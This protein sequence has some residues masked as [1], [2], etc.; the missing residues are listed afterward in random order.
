MGSSPLTRGKLVLP[1][2]GETELGLIPAHAGKTS[3]PRSRLAVP[4]AH[5][6]SR[7]E[8]NRSRMD[9]MAR[10]GSSPLTR[11][12]RGDGHYPRFPSRLIP[13]HAGKTLGFHQTESSTWAHPRSRGENVL[14]APMIVL[15]WGS[16]PLTRGKLHPRARLYACR[17]LIPAH[18]GKTL[19]STRIPSSIWGSSPLTRGKLN[20]R[21]DLTLPEGLIP[22]HAGKTSTS[23]TST[24][25]ITAHPR[26]RGENRYE[27]ASARSP[28]GSS[29]LTRGK[30][31]A[32]A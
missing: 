30:H 6:R 31:S 29:P 21:R 32:R 3:R 19:R 24:G 17:G 18:A 22:A 10:P 13:A 4:R 12:K 7:G 16:S 27:S 26:S 9:S 5:P 2:D 14:A 11:G 25:C 8:N 15:I 23:S 1:S 20:E 28:L